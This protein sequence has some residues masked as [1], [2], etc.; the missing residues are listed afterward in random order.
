MT[1]ANPR[2][3]GP[4]RAARFRCTRRQ[5]HRTEPNHRVRAVIHSP[6]A[7]RPTPV[8][9]RAISAETQAARAAQPTP[10]GS[11]RP[12]KRHARAGWCSGPPRGWAR[13]TRRPTPSLPS[14]ATPARSPSPAASPWRATPPPP[15]CP[16]SAPG[17]STC[18]RSSS[19]SSSPPTSS[20]SCVLLPPNYPPLH[21]LLLPPA[22]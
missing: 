22:G 5:R 3:L 4:C 19:S 6:F 9:A 13:A 7:P 8:R 10:R 15:P 18:Y 2:A 21:L 14:S 20:P 12:S 11:L 16:R 1:G 17:S